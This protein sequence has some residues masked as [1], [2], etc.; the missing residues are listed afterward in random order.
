MY[1]ELLPRHAKDEANINNEV[2]ELIGAL[3]AFA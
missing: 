1:A 3:D 2:I